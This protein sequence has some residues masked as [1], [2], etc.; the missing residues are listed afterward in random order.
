MGIG[1]FG[2][3]FNR[4][5]EMRHRFAEAAQL[6]LMTPTIASAMELFIFTAQG[7][8][9]TRFGSFDQLFRRAGLPES[10]AEI[11]VRDVI[12]FGDFESA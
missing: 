6:L 3:N 12:S 9:A 11:D 1:V 8:S 4:F 5:Q 7:S 2:I 10:R